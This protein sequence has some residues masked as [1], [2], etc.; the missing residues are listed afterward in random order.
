[1]NKKVF[2][3]I[4]AFSSIFILTNCGSKNSQT[5]A[6]INEN[7]IEKVKTDSV[8][9]QTV[10]RKLELSST[11]EGYETMK[12]SPSL[13]GNIEHIFVDVGSYV[14]A[15]QMLVRMD[16]NKYNSAKLAYTNANIEF[17]RVKALKETNTVS[18]QVFDQAKLGYD[19]TKE[20]LNFIT[21]NTFVR[22][23]FSGVVSAKNYIDGELYSGMPILVLTQINILKALISIPENFYPLVKQGMS[24]KIKSDIY[25]NEEFS[26]K[27][28]T[29]YP[30]IDPSTHTFNAKVKII[31][32]GN[33][34][35]PG[36][37]VRV[38]LDLGETEAKVI[39]YQAVLKLTG[40]N[41][42]YVFV[43][44]GGVAKRTSVK[45]GERYND[46]V[47]ILSDNINVGDMIVVVGQAKLV[48]GSKIEIVK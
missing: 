27:I 21:E 16:Q 15:G 34:L 28:E 26:A 10:S 1:M 3:A 5:D 12:V 25:K 46:N 14:S 29:V 30:T 11:L 37:F 43:D 22:A 7:R 23:R 19:Q 38:N 17:E 33:K 47:E 6:D 4:L 39:P 32:S 8:K 44:N 48:D 9:M 41:E 2:L 45:L 13:T 42:R 18:Q 31:N 40:S 24:V 35:R 20:N 36:M